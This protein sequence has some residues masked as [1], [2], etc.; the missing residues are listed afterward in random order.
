LSINLDFGLA[1]IRSTPTCES[2]TANHIH[3]QKLI[4]KSRNLSSKV[5]IMSLTEERSTGVLEL[6]L[7]EKH[8]E[9]LEVADKAK[10][11]TFR[12][13]SAP[14]LVEVFGE[15]L[16]EGIFKLAIFSQGLCA[17]HSIRVELTEKVVSL[18]SGHNHWK[19]K[20]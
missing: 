11:I 3:R 12:E 7:F 19:L 6:R 5:E 20:Q 15:L 4:C 14:D 18:P 8:E 17:R 1:K 2:R 9:V 13:E 16:R 10:G